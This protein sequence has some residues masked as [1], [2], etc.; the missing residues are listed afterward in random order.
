M[1]EQG[2]LFTFKLRLTLTRFSSTRPTTETMNLLAVCLHVTSG[3]KTMTQ[4]MTQMPA[5]M[6]S[7]HTVKVAL[8]SRH[9]SEQFHKI[10]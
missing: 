10:K 3:L 1:T 4:I 5:I 8:H 7:T 2:V 9:C 6:T